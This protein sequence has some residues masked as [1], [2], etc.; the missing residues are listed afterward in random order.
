M[1][2]KKTLLKNSSIN[3]LGYGYLL[4]LS[5]FS[6]PMLLKTLGIEIFGVYLVYSG[7]IPLIST[8][9]FGLTTALVRYL[10]LPNMSGYKKTLYWQTCF[11]QFIVISMA[12]FL[13]SLLLNIFSIQNVLRRSLG[14]EI[15]CFLFNQNNKRTS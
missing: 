12:M 11:W 13:L 3:L 4:L 5:F 2:I 10:S 14:P 7:L 6:I 9:N 8:I 15:T 1:S